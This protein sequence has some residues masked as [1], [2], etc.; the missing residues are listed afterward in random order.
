M[1]AMTDRQ[2]DKLLEDISSIKNAISRNREAIRLI[3]LPVHFRLLYLLVGLSVIGF[4]LAFH[5]LMRHHGS[6]EAIPAI[7]KTAVYTAI[8]MVWILLGWIKWLKLAGSLSKID[9]RFTVPYFLQEFFSFRIVHVYWPLLVLVICICTVFVQHNV[10]FY[11]IPTIAVG[12]GLVHN[13][14]GS[15]TQLWQWLISGYWFLV[16]GLFLLATGPMYV[17]LAASLSLGIGALLFAIS[18]WA[19]KASNEE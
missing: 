7:T 8:V 12:L 18:G 4:S 10:D 19:S 17:P 3:L 15:V 11:V 13:F 14:I 6:F 9:K 5:L 2:V 16:T 1:N